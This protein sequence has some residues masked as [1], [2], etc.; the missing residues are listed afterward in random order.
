VQG[1]QPLFTP[2][3]E[4]VGSL[5]SL[6]KR[7]MLSVLGNHDWRLGRGE[8]YNEKL[9]E[10]G[11]QVLNNSSS[12]LERGSDRLWLVGVDDPVTGRDRLEVALEGTDDRSPRL[13]LSH[14][15]QLFPLAASLG[16]D[17]MLSGHT[18]GGQIRFPVLGALY[19]PRMGFFPP[20]D[21]GLYSKGATT[22]IVSGGLGE[23]GLPIRFNIRPEVALITL[24]CSPSHQTLRQSAA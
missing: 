22:L 19:V 8:A 24:R 15:P 2:A 17:L 11:V 21:Y 5:L 13:L 10:A 7:P 16:L 9:R 1:E 14:S 23:S 3:L 6:S 18:H 12:L 4:L 20:W